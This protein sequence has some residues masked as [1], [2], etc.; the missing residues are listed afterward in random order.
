MIVWEII[1]NATKL[2]NITPHLSFNVFFVGLRYLSIDF[3]LY[4]LRIKSTVT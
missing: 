2:F 1:H 3:C 4:D